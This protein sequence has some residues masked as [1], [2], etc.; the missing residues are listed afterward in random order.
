VVIFLLFFDRS[1]QTDI[2]VAEANKHASGVGFGQLG[3][4]RVEL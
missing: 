2:H 3:I 1:V 4:S